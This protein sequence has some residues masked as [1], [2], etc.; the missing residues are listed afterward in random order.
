MAKEKMEII[1]EAALQNNC[2]EC[3]NKSLKLTFS[4]KH[5]YGKLLH[6]VTKEFSHEM[7][8]SK[9]GSIIYPVKWTDDIER[10]FEYYQKTVTPIRATLEFRPLFYVLVLLLLAVAGALAYFMA[11]GF[12][13]I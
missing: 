5:T 4:Q 6:R 1:K 3:F 9:C 10:S 13:S 2:P 12:P 7:K 8:C 11:Q